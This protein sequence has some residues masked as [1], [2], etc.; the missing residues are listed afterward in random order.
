MNPSITSKRIVWLYDGDHWLHPFI[1]AGVKSLMNA[2][3]WVCVVDRASTYKDEKISYKHISSAV[4]SDNPAP[5]VRNFSGVFTFWRTLWFTLVQRP[6]IVIA[7]HPSNLIVAWLAAKMLRPRLVYYPYEVY[8]EQYGEV[9]WVWKHVERYVLKTGIDALITQNQPRSQIYVEERAS[10]VSPTIVHNYKP[11]RLARHSGKLYEK[12]NLPR[13]CMVVL[14][15]GSLIEGRCLDRLVKSAAYLPVNSKLV[16]MGRVTKWW[17]KNIEPLLSEPLLSQ[18][19][20]LAPAVP[21]DE[22]LDYVADADVGVIIYDGE[23]RNNYYCEP[24]KLS[25]YVLAGV[26][27]VAPGFPTISPLVEEYG[28]GCVFDNLDPVAIAQTVS[29]V[30]SVPK[31]TWALALDRAKKSLIWE[32]QEATFIKSVC[33]E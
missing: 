21:H 12:L 23:V 22:V 3:Y 2:G 27:I 6:N 24:G 1:S 32:T 19:I 28:I 5:L 10:R 13:D 33:G 31:E 14:Y 20:I 30:L 25:D 29:F 8:G 26:P 7:T 9:R 4:L 15:E 16:F 11:A 18:R 17:R